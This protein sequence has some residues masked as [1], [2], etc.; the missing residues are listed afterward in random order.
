LGIFL[1]SLLWG[2]E[3]YLSILELSARGYINKK[4]QQEL[5]ARFKDWQKRKSLT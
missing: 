1:S 4:I 2:V 5:D 3:R